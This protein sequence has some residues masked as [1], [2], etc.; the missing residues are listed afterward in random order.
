MAVYLPF[1]GDGVIT[2]TSYQIKN[3][4]DI[5]DITVKQHIKTI[6]EVLKISEMKTERERWFSEAYIAVN[7]R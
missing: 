3:D 5:L 4:I 7:F 1:I 2:A 6:R